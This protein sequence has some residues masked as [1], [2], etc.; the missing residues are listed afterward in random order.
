MET[1]QIYERV[2]DMYMHNKCKSFT[3]SG[4]EIMSNFRNLN[5]NFETYTQNSKGKVTG[6]RNF[7]SMETSCI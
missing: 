3:S 4:T 6:D 5:T 7:T 1:I 2:V